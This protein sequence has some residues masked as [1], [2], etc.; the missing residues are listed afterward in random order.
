MWWHTYYPCG[1]RVNTWSKVW[2]LTGHHIS[3]NKCSFMKEYQADAEGL[4]PSDGKVRAL[5]DA[6]L[7]SFQGLINY[8]TRFLPNLSSKLAPLYSLLAKQLKSKWK[9][10]EKQQES[11]QLAKVAQFGGGSLW[12]IET[13][14]PCLWMHLHMDCNVMTHLLPMQVKG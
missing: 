10:G 2:P 4:Q 3:R 11:F 12:R 14:S 7:R 8:Y 5:K 9:W 13:I 6:E 1:L